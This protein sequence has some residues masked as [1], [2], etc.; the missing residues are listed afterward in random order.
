M[1]LDSWSRFTTAGEGAHHFQNLLQCFICSWANQF[2]REY[3]LSFITGSFYFSLTWRAVS[4]LNWIFHQTLS[5]DVKTC[6]FYFNSWLCI[7]SNIINILIPAGAET[8]CWYVKILKTAPVMIK[9]CFFYIYIFLIL[10]QTLA[11]Y[12]KF[13]DST[14]IKIKAFWHRTRLFL[15]NKQRELCIHV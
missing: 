11:V 7:K 4:I 10:F 14:K 1:N 8:A 2:G 3:K 5:L 9:L 12:F 6:S 13:W 15:F